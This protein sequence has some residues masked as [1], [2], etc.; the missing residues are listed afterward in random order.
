MN[1]NK[2]NYDYE[3]EYFQLFYASG[4]EYGL[5]TNARNVGLKIYNIGTTS[6]SYKGATFVPFSE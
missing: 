1:I 3:M 2:L 4:N 5:A 6:F